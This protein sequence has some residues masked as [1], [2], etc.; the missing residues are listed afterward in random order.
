MTALQE[1][2]L[3]LCAELEVLHERADFELQEA[4]T[5]GESH[6]AANRLATR[7]ALKFA[8]E[9]LEALLTTSFGSGGRN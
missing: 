9:R 6:K 8:K 4:Q 2:I 7:D 5:Y 1:S 3:H